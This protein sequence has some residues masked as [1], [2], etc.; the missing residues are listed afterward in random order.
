MMTL[1][2]RNMYITARGGCDVLEMEEIAVSEEFQ[3]LYEE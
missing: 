1:H 3:N 2:T